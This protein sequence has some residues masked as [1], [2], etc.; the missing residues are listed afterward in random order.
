MVLQG[1]IDEMYPQKTA[2]NVNCACV[3]A[4]SVG[5]FMN[6]KTWIAI[7]VSVREIFVLTCD[8]SLVERTMLDLLLYIL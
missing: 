3:V 4:S 8:Y 7:C 2:V 6:M 5:M 1:D